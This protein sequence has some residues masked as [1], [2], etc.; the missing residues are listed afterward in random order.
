[1]QLIGMLFQTIVRHTT[2]WVPIIII[3]IH[4]VIIGETLPVDWCL[5]L[6][7]AL[8]LLHSFCKIDLAPIA[9][10]IPEAAPLDLH[11]L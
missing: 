1:M 2:R 7:V 10:N 9:G 11:K 4:C 8:C 5:W 3:V 6:C